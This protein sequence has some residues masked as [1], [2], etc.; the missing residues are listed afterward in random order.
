MIAGSL[1]VLGA[2][3]P[4]RLPGDHLVPA[5]LP[6]VPAR[7]PGVTVSCR[8]DRSCLVV[9]LSGALDVTSS[10]ALREWLLRVLRLAASRLVID[11]S[12]VSHAD[13][14]ALT[15]LVGTQRRAGLLGGFLRLAAPTP[16]VASALRATGLDMR[17][18][19]YPTVEAAIS[20]VV[21][22]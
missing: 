5:R 4:D 21:P 14:S 9:T 12:S 18:D 20:T 17:L 2:R 13:A 6:G 11:L 8:A 19:I 10:P 16:R 22:A 1:P 15:V 7:L 3:P